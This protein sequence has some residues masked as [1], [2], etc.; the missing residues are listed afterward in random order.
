MRIF[1]T[2]NKGQLGRSLLTRLAKTDHVVGGGDLP[3][4]DLT[5]PVQADNS[6]GQF[7]PDLVIHTA[8]LTNVDYCAEH[9][10]EA[11]KINGFGTQNVVLACRRAGAMMLAISTNEVFDGK[12]SNPYQEYD[13]RNP[14][15][16]YGY[17]KFVAEQYVE[18]FAPSYMIVRTSWMFSGGGVNFI[19]KIISRAQSGE[20]LKVVTDEIGSPTYASDLATALIDVAQLGRPGIYHLTNSGE[21]SRFEFACEIIRLVNLDVPIAPTKL[22][23]FPRASTPPPYAPLANVFAAEIG[24]I[25]RPWQQALAEYVAEFELKGAS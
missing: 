16:P 2:G 15:N 20:K 14:V 7:R 18:R 17:S 4:W 24:V 6:I 3:E 11:L 21:C 13:Q 9:P 8:A 22:A 12:A 1:I 23:N 19:H 10:G 5:D 25:L